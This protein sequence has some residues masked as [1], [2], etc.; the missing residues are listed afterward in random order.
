MIDDLYAV[1]SS[2]DRMLMEYQDMQIAFMWWKKLH[3]KNNSV[4][5]MILSL[6]VIV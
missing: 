5:M 6:N 3:G 2:K 4:Y 1:Y